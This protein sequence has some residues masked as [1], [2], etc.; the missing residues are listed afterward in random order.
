MT[1]RFYRRAVVAL[2]LLPLFAACGRTPPPTPSPP[3]NPGETITG[4]ERLGWDQ[5]AA[6]AAELATFRYA[7]YVDGA[8]SEVADVTCAGTA[9]ANGFACSGRLPSMTNGSHTLELAAFL[10]DASGT[11][12]SGRSPAL[13][14]TVAALT[15]PAPADAHPLIA[16][17]IVA[18]IDRVELRAQPLA[19]D[20]NDAVDLAILPD[21][22]VLVAERGGG[23]RMVQDAAATTL[24]PGT[25]TEDGGIASLAVDPEFARTGHLFVVHTPAG[26]FRLVRYRLTAG[27]LTDRM[28]LMRDVAASADAAAAVR[29]GADRKLYVAFDDA[30]SRDA[31]AR[32]SE[33]NGKILRLNAD[34]GTPDD[35][36]AASPVYWTGLRE[37]RGLG[38]TA[39]GTL[40][41]TD[42]R[43]EGLA[44]LAALTIESLRPRR[45]SARA[46]YP[47]PDPFGARTLAFHHGEDTP[48]FRG[49]LL[50]AANDAAYLL[51][52][53]F[54]ETN[55]QRIS[56]TERLLEGRIGPVRAVA[57]ARSGAIYVASDSALWRLAPLTPRPAV[58]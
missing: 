11:L 2:A 37:P 18:T 34:G 50:L 29:F 15:T 54:D 33:W 43:G 4:R 39:D 13:S 16:G 58:R 20:L 49:N 36:P 22:A 46:S 55:P 21:G 57:V 32:A 1:R 28:P 7:I 26:A 38:W 48:E 27:A 23:V 5:Q 30:G 24:D 40:W 6:T 19:T 56:A 9:G 31:A 42:E 45:S 47:L 53:R 41:V 12:E 44:R 25:R 14:V 3:G 17:D 10:L 8:R 51:R 52:I 35:Q